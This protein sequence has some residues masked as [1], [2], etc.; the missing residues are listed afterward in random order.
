MEG[1]KKNYDNLHVLYNSIE[2]K[3]KF[4]P[5]KNNEICFIG[6]LVPEK[7]A[8]IYCEAIEEI[9]KDYTDWN[10]TLIGSSKAGQTIPKSIYEKNLINKFKSIGKNTHYLGF[11]DN[12]S[13]QKKISNAS[14]IV[15]PSIWE[16]P[17]CLVAIEGLCNAAVVISSNKGGLPE[18]L[19][20]NGIML[21]D[22][23]KN[24]LKDKI[25]ELLTNTKLIK[26]YQK[27]SWDNYKFNSSKNTKKQDLIRSQILINFN[28]K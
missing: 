13:V 2:R 8:H 5:K 22:I 19:D 3:H 15:I 4:I 25:I 27:K 18:V 26:K 6:R 14:I 7:G 11:I 10:F 1:L 16:E 21:K 24:T 17:L 23:N 28:F 12:E 20:D 9:A